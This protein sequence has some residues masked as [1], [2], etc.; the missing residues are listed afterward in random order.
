MR[1]ESCNT[2]RSSPTTSALG[3]RPPC[4]AMAGRWI[5]AKPPV[6]R[7]SMEAVAFRDGRLV[8]VASTVTT[9]AVGPR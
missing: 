5:V 1:T 2:R 9:S 6:A 7:F 4:A 3:A 8:A